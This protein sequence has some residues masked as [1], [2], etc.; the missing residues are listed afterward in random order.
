MNYKRLYYVHCDGYMV[1]ADSM[2]QAE[3]IAGFARTITGQKYVYIKEVVD[4]CGVRFTADD[5]AMI[6]YT[7]K[8]GGRVCAIKWVRTKTMSGLKEALGF[9][10]WVDAL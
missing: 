2:Q 8:G 10:D 6:R 5:M 1:A 7:C 3:D 4:F 9:V